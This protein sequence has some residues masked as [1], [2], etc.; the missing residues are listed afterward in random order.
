MNGRGVVRPYEGPQPDL[1]T[2]HEN[3]PEIYPHLL[4]GGSAYAQGRFDILFAYPDKPRT[5]YSVGASKAYDDFFSQIELDLTRNDVTLPENLPFIFGYFIYLGYELA[6][7]WEPRLGHLQTAYLPL[8]Y[9]Q[10]FHGAVICDFARKMTFITADDTDTA[11]RIAENLT[12]LRL[13]PSRLIRLNHIHEEDPQIY[14]RNIDRVKRYIKAGDI[15]QANLSRQYKASVDKEV[16]PQDLMRAI[17][18]HNPAAFSA[19]ALLEDIAIISAS[20]ERL[21]AVNGARITTSPIAGTVPRMINPAQDVVQKKELISHP[22]ERAE[23]IML[24]DLERNDLGRLCKNGSIIVPRLMEIETYATVHH[25]VSTIEGILRPEI[26]L[27]DIIMS[28]FP[29]GTITGC[30]KIRCIE[31]LG[32]LEMYPREVYTGSLGY[33]NYNGNMDLNILIRTAVYCDHQLKWR[34]GGGIVADSDPDRELTE[35]RAKARGL[36]RA[37]TL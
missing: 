1:L 10:W 27:I 3:Y 30:P 22:K 9:A 23:H 34:V 37:F 5:L 11:D 15:F 29:G 14:L 17:R 7:A 16:R 36:L 21:V 2:V 4:C 12:R 20:P 13:S 19:L 33:I 8:A 26:K 24:V 31:I 6:S 28:L 35:T 18:T 32:E 25:L